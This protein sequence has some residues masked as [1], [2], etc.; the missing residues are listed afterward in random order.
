M[1]KEIMP[2]QARLDAPGTLHHIMIRGIDGLQI[3]QDPADRQDLIS[4]IQ[5]LVKTTGNRVLAWVLM[6][7]HVLC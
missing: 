6:E 7:T 5:G 2:R 4:R 3:F 1:V